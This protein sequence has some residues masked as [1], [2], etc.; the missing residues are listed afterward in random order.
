MKPIVASYCTTFLKPEMLHIYRQ[1]TGLRRYRTVVLAK[2]RQHPD[3]F[4]FDDVELLP[5]PRSNFIRRFY[6]K[7][8]RRAPSIFYRGEFQVLQ[9]ALRRADARL[10]HIYFG[11]TGVHLLPFIEAW[12]GRCVVSFHGADVMLRPHQSE[13]EGRLRTLLEKIPLV[14]AR[15]ESLRE[16]L[17]ALGCPPEKIRLNRTGIPLGSFP[18]HERAPVEMGKWQFVQAC[19]LIPKKGLRTALRAFAIFQKTNPAARFVIAGEG[20]MQP[21]LEAFVREIGLVESVE[22]RGFLDQPS[23]LELYR[24]SHVFLHPSEMTSD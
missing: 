7:Y 13:Y 5:R 14:L 12:E 2:E 10:M 23:L 17:I 20:P 24:S 21:E 8:I 16:R 19:R 1:V 15:S 4:P 6:L 9:K 22:F 18:L 3:R 11:H